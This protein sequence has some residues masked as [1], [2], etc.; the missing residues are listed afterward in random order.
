[1]QSMP[2]GVRAWLRPR[3]GRWVLYIAEDLLSSLGGGIPD[4][5][6]EAITPRWRTT[7]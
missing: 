2:P 1:M 4:A 6:A 3:A 5:G 7:S